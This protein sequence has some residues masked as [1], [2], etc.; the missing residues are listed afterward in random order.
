MGHTIDRCIMRLH[1]EIEMPTINVIV[2]VATFFCHSR[3][4]AKHAG[5]CLPHYLEKV[6]QRVLLTKD[7]L[8]TAA[9]W[10]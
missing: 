3:H 2:E 5:L 8:E 10:R 4:V 6:R 9:V 7:G 1:I